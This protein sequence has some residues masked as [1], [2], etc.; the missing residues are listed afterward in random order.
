MFPIEE[1][2]VVERIGTLKDRHFFQ[3][4]PETQIIKYLA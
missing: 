4:D 1:G 2:A 3:I